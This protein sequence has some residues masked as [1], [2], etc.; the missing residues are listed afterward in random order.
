MNPGAGPHRAPFV[1]HFGEGY[2][3]LT[4]QRIAQ[5]ILLADEIKSVRVR[6]AGQTAV[7]VRP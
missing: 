5:E 1:L 3:E 4:V 7:T 6:Y 2:V